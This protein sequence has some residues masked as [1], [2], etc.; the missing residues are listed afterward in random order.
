[1]H[2][3]EAKTESELARFFSG[4]EAGLNS[5]RD[6]RT[7]YDEQIA[8][9]FNMLRFFNPGETKIS[10]ILAFFLNPK[11]E[12]GQKS[13][14]LRAFIEHFDLSDNID[15]LLSA[16]ETITVMLED[17]TQ[18]DRR[19]DITVFFEAAKFAVG[20]EN[21]IH[22]K[23]QQTQV[24][25][26]CVELK[27]RTQD[28]F[29]LLYL[30]LDRRNPSEESIPKEAFEA[31]SKV[32]KIKNIG[33]GDI[34]ELLKKYEVVCRA[35]NVREFVRQFQ[36]YINQVYLGERSMGENKFVLEYLREHPEILK[37]ADAIREAVW[38]VKSECFSSFW[39]A[40]A[41]RL[42]IQGINLDLTRMTFCDSGYSEALVEHNGSPFVAA[43][44]LKNFS[45]FYE[46]KIIDSP[47]YITIRMSSERKNLSQQLKSK[48]ERFE[49]KLKGRKLGNVRVNVGGWWCA[50]VP[51]PYIR[52][53]DG[54][55]VCSILKD[56]D[57]G[58]MLNC[59]VEAATKISKYIE[60]TESLWRE[61]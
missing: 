23:D 33:Y 12:H 43:S 55:E 10:E 17:P 40:V 49:E 45:I 6:V 44:E 37:H 19:I 1:M 57:G 11:R 61:M 47:I 14:F 31:L 4:L 2:D 51:L 46:P 32:G 60:I 24:R 27:N 25:D 50:T 9:D 34:V 59:A 3:G 13:A 53:S 42:K 41:D 21:K 7:A 22:A 16:D 8:F 15:A 29:I 36:Q 39:R 30:S 56:K 35:D 26:Y 5:L 18:H 28:N 20:I 48:V 54:D 38:S 58:K 52:F